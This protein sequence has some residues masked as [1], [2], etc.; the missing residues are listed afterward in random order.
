[1]V[2]K[3]HI[4][5]A[6]RA[7]RKALAASMCL[8]L[9]SGALGQQ[10]T[11]GAPTAPRKDTRAARAAYLAGARALDRNNVTEAAHA[12]EQAARL[13]PDNKE[14]PV[15]LELARQHQVTA[16][17]Q[18]AGRAHLLGD[19]AGA[20]ALLAQAR[21]L[22]PQNPLVLEH[23]VGGAAFAAQ[24]PA[25]NPGASSA[26]TQAALVSTSS[27][28]NL[29]PPV[30]AGAIHLKPAEVPRD[31]HLRGD[32]QEVL[33]Q[34]AEAFGIRASIDESVE[35]KPMRFDMDKTTFEQ[36]MPIAMSMAHVFS[37]ALG[38]TSALFAR[39][40]AQNRQQ[41]EPLLEETIYVPAMTA[42]QINELSTVLRQVFG[43]T[44]A[45]VQTTL[46]AIVVRA[47]EAV[48]GP[49]NE[50]VREL[51][52]S[53]SEVVLDVKFYET[54]VTRSRNI[55][56][57]LP[58]Q[59][60]VYSVDAAAQQLVQ[61]N[62]SL[63]QQAIAQGYISATASNLQ[64]A[65]ALIASG[66]VQSSLLSS[67]LGFFGN[68]LTLTGVTETGSFG[69]NLA[70]NESDT[71][72][73]DAVQIHVG[74]RQT[75]T[76]RSGTRYPVLSS[77]YTSGISTAA[78]ALS[79][80]TIN[81]VSVANLLAQY[82]GGSSVTI[83]QVQYEDLGVTLKATPII[84]RSGRITMTLDMKI[85][86]LAGGS[87]DGIP[88]LGSRQVASNITVGDGETA[89]LVSNLSRTETAAVSGLPGLSELPGFQVPLDKNA[90]KDSSQL[91]VLITP[92]VVRRRMNPSAG[93][94]MRV[95]G[96][97]ESGPAGAAPGSLTATPANAPLAPP[98]GLTPG[99]PPAG[100]PIPS[101]NDLPANPPGAPPSGPPTQPPAN[102]PTS[103]PANSPG[104]STTG[105][106]GS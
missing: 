54:D 59:A 69:L 7:R 15:A 79:S 43:I 9:A 24:A 58:T 53:D 71:R 85:E 82:A 86:A 65:L 64:I 30:I 18:R 40:D 87:L 33:R 38:E 35:H 90:E 36:A 29:P 1:M 21:T 102:A 45:S 55:G 6:S 49:M 11:P 101:P 46:G 12:F 67:T 5:A 88:V 80:A 84:Q 48:L 13:D 37:V 51:I 8:A 22:D 42:E 78:S 20:E 103:P 31:L 73:L 52:E 106:P 100:A 47:P 81:G 34:I 14:Y 104:S 25:Q 4:D 61:N 77:T 76:F 91:V 75:G 39:D 98:P 27:S 28:S 94:P 92:H 93:P 68:G 63:V 62:Q 60:G 19:S 96:G 50:T 23:P 57:T 99:N 56:T 44:R 10:T 89:M 3:T 70:L 72:A 105:P 32:S 74:D 2:L 17:V 83:P 16:L 41:F 26:S 66:L 97:L 95:P